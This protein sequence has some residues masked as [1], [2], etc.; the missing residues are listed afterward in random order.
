[1]ARLPRFILPDQPQHVILRGNN[2]TEIFCAEAD[3]RFYLDKLRLACEKHGCDI[4]AYVLMTNHVHLLITPHKEQSL[5]K[6]LQMLGRYYVQFFNHCYRRTGTL[7]EG[8]Y[9]ATL[10][11]TEAYLLTCMRYIELNPIRAGMVAHPSE[12]PWSSYGCNALGPTDNLVNPHPEYRHLGRTDEERRSAYR[13]L[14]EYQISEESINAIREATNK[15]WVLGN[16]RFKQSIQEK[17]KRRVAPAAKG[18]DR[19]SEQFKIN[20]L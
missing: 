6:A 5:S 12:Y 20:R 9:K 1:M 11:D 3:Y 2:R 18:G 8:R 17:L 7:W 19:K 10:I 14:F 13:Q 15:A 4:H 16:D